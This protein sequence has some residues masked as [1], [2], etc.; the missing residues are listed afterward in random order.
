MDSRGADEFNPR[1]ARSDDR[2]RLA[3]YRN[4]PATD[5]PGLY[6]PKQ[7][8]FVLLERPSDL[9]RCGRYESVVNTGNGNR[10]EFLSIEM[11]AMTIQKTEVGKRRFALAG[12]GRMAGFGL[13]L[14][15]APKPA[16]L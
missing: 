13:D 15:C 7:H 2:Q 11:V 3:K 4:E 9:H 10:T 14:A 12:V 5:W 6:A 8:E 1:T 16:D